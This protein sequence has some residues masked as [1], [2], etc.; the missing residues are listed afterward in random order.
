MVRST[1]IMPFKHYVTSPIFAEE[2]HVRPPAYDIY[3]NYPPKYPPDINVI[4]DPRMYPYAQYLTLT[5]LIPKDEYKVTLFCNGLGNAL[6]YMN[7][8]FTRDDV[9]FR[10]N[11]SR[12]HKLKLAR[13][14]RNNCNDTFSP[15]Q[16][17]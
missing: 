14:F 3:V 10:D 9:A 5:N 16:S 11:I 15:Y 13:R 4:K 17:F 6:G 1:E 8:E 12:I 2:W 7:S